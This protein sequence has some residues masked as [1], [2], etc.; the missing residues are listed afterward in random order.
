[1]SE[2][3]WLELEEVLEMHADQLDQRGELPGCATKGCWRRPSPRPA[4]LLGYRPDVGP[5]RLAAAYA[6]G[7]ARNGT[8]IDG[9]KRVAL[10]TAVSFLLFNG[11]RLDAVEREAK[12]MMLRL[13]A[14][15]IDGNVF[16]NWLDRNTVWAGRRI[17]LYGR[18]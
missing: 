8:F 11:R 10:V 15:E 7:I 6:S 17:G 1:M 12:H 16:A 18:L 14:G 2:P 5:F 4:D 3:S 9:D 13:A